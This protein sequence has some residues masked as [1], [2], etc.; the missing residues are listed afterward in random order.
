MND[1][2][3]G[4][5]SVLSSGTVGQEITDLDGITIAWT[6]DAWVAQVIVQL[7]VV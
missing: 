5:F 2:V 4:P 3:L 1:M 6:T 7:L